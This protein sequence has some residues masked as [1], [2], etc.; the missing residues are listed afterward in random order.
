MS[1][2]FVGIQLDLR[3]AEEV[4]NDLKEIDSLLK[5][6]N[7]RQ[8]VKSGL[9]DLKKDA[10]AARGEIEKLEKELEEL[11]EI[12]KLYG[13]DKPDW[14]DEDIEEYSNQLKV[15]RDRLKDIKQAERE[16]QSSTRNMGRTFKEEFNAWSSK[17]AHVGGAMQSLGN[18]LTRLST[19]FKRLM[20]GTVFA[21]GYKFLNLMTEGF[22]SATRRA[23]IL[24]TYKPVFKAMGAGLDVEGNWQDQL[25]TAYNKVYESVIGLPT[26]IDEIVNEWKLLTI[27]T[28]D[29]DKAADL[30]IAA[31]N[32]ILAS[33]ADDN[34]QQIARRELRT[35]LTTGKLT[36]RQWD[37]LRKGIPVAWN[38]IEQDLKEEN[39]ISGS[40]LEALKSGDI[41]ANQFADLLIDEGINGKTKAVVNEMLH[42][43]NAATANIRNAFSNMGKNILATLDEI[44]LGATG[45]DTIDYLIGM[46]Q[47]IGSFSEG[48]QGW[49]RENSDVILNFINAVKGVDWGSLARGFG[50]G[51]IKNLEKLT[52]ILEWF[53][54]RDLGWIGRFLAKAPM[55][56][57]ALTILGGAIKGLRGPLAFII[58]LFSRGGG[59][60]GGLF[61][62]KG[63]GV[64]GGSVIGAGINKGTFLG[65]GKIGLLSAEITGII[66][67]ITAMATGFAALDM[68]F[69]SS[70]FN[71]FKKITENLKIGLDNL[72]QVKESDVDMNAVKD[73]VKKVSEMYQTLSGIPMSVSVTKRMATSTKN[74]RNAIWQ[75]RRVA[76][77]INQASGTS[78]DV[79]GF[80][81]FVSQIKDAI[82]SLEDLN[83]NME[84]DIKVVLGA[85]FESS[86][87]GVIDTIKKAKKRI[88]TQT[89]KEVSFT[90]PVKVKFSVTSNFASALAKILRQK[91]TLRDTAG[92]STVNYGT[93]IA[94]PVRPA[95]GGLIYRAH[96]GGVPW[97]RVGTDTVPAM[98]TPGEYVHN[99]RAV[100]MFGIDFM[101]KVNNLDM[102]GAMNELMHRAGHMA[103]IN[104]GTSITNNNYNNQKVVI[105]NSNAGA[106]YTFKTASR[107]VGAF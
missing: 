40:L 20:G 7:G 15:A 17:I 34:A 67:A 69:L 26:G 107:F 28:Q 74:I 81:G 72:S 16:V 46:K 54:G 11:R 19:P 68:K 106:G 9:T 59:L 35:L 86:V 58:T 39:K 62:G 45:K 27:A 44:L 99:K 80:Q 97:K 105:N 48:T 52:K 38:A 42:T 8:K 64:G 30:A 31:N 50:D 78:V 98:L 70:A 18:A 41:T 23:D 77:Q 89:K 103:N 12:S 94:P 100:S 36:E 4:Y 43:Y 101:R 21:A 56:G 85:G 5:S 13:K 102:K 32:A 83:Q 3:G 22:D 24:A 60:L 66:G 29:Y 1:V 55:W 93:P 63:G 84:L 73:L 2:E 95:N 47:I 51:L 87:N 37:S 82:G 6:F 25:E 79:G 57:T 104:R 90:I 96:G 14:V 65:V 88:E 92:S 10:V 61:G 53:E 75:L 91:Q 76:Y 49:M 71:S 33:G